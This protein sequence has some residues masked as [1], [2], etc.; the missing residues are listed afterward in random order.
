MLPAPPPYTNR[1]KCRLFRHF[2]RLVSRA[3]LAGGGAQSK[4]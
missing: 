1:P 2:G 4:E 3:G